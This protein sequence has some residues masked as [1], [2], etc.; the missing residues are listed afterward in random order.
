[1]TDRCSYFIIAPLP[2]NLEAFFK[3]RIDLKSCLSHIMR[4]TAQYV[5]VKLLTLFCRQTPGVTDLLC[6]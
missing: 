4:I 6:T 2:S 5:C 1:M 3:A